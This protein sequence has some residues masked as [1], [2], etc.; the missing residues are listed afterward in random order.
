MEVELELEVVVVEELPE[1]GLRGVRRD[2][3]RISYTVL[4]LAVVVPAV[5]VETDTA[6][7]SAGIVPSV[8]DAS[9][10]TGFDFGGGE[11]K[12]GG[13]VS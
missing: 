4:L 10:P 5:V 3:W 12:I 7:F 8:V 13:T 2:S 6:V 9:T 11:G 1:E